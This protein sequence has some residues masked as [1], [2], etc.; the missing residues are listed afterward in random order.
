[1]ATRT[2]TKATLGKMY[3]MAGV[4]VASCAAFACVMAV[5]SGVRYLWRIVLQHLWGGWSAHTMRQG[6]NR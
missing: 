6:R 5:Y 2:V 3:D 4:P 1:M